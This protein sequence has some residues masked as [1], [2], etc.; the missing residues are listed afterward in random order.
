MA[1]IKD[2]FRRK[3]PPAQHPEVVR[4][5]ELAESARQKLRTETDPERRKIL[6]ILA[7]KPDYV[8]L[9]GGGSLFDT[10]NMSSEE[11]AKVEEALKRLDAKLNRRINGPDPAD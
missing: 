5:H 2:I 7:R 3:T 10:S 6:K 11:I 4:I 9:S 1:W 8:I